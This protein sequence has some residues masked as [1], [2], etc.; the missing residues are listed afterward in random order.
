M[1]APNDTSPPRPEGGAA[2]PAARAVDGDLLA[3]HRALARPRARPRDRRAYYFGVTGRINAF[4]VAFQIPNLVRALVADA[5]LSS[6][7]VPVFSELLEKG[8]RKRAWRVASTPLLADAARP[9]RAHRALHPAR[10]AAHAAVR[11]SG[12]RRRARRRALAHPL[13]DRRPARA[14]RDRRRDPEQLRPLHRAGAH[15]GRLEPRRSSSASSSASRGSHDES[16]QLYVYAGSIVARDGDPAPAAAAVA[17]GAA[18]VGSRWSIDW[19]DPAVKRVLVLMLPGDD[20]R[21]AD[22]RQRRR[23][24]VLRV[25]A[26]RPGARAGGDRRGVPPLHAAAGDLLGRGRD[27][28]LPDARAARRPR[29]HR[30][31]PAS[32]RRRPAPDRLPARAG[33]RSCRSCS[34]SRSCA[35]STSAAS[36]RAEDTV[37]VARACGVLARARLQRLD[38]DAEPQL[39]RLQTTWIPTGVALGNLALNAALDAV[40]YRLGIWG[41]PLAT[42]IVNI[43][44][45]TRAARAA[46]SP[47]SASSTSGA[48]SGVVRA[49]RRRRRPRRGA[50]YGAWRG[51]DDVLGTGL[52]RPAVWRSAP[53]LAAGGRRLRRRSPGRWGCA[54]S[55]RCYR[56]EPGATSPPTRA[57]PPMEQ[58]RIRNF[59]I[60]AHI[61]HG[62]STLADR[63]LELTDTVTEPRH[64]RRSCSTR[65]TSSASAGSRSRPRP[66]A[67]RWKGHEL[68]LI[69]TPGHVDFTYEVSRSLQACEGALLVVD[70]AQGIEAQTLANA[71]LAIEND[72]EI[73]PVVNKIDLPQADPD[74]AAREIAELARRR[75]PSASC[76]SRR[77]PASG[78]DRGARR[79]RRADPARRRAI[80]TRRP[81]A[82]DLRLLL[83]PVPR[84][85]R[86]R[87]RRRRPL[88]DAA[89]RCARWRRAPSF[90]AEELGFMSPTLR[91]S[92]ALG[93][94]EVGYVITGLKDV[95]RLR[96][97]DTLT[98]RAAPGRRAAARLQG[99]QADGLRRALP[100]RLRRLPGAARRARAAEAERRA[101]SSTSPRRRRR[102]ASASAAASSACCT[103]RSSASGSSA[104]STSTCS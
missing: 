76:G 53:A 22:Q 97:G 82:L 84:R 95:S 11:R 90:D 18:T 33:Q 50:S 71:Y 94:G 5:A 104:S 64:A 20:R 47:A 26:A 78:V 42:S 75:R 74:G 24:H 67:C 27:G 38:A 17:A 23:R 1:D 51:L 103:W 60:I 99:R 40:F 73:V 57:E 87:P 9:R 79:D 45:A 100:D 77:R 80:P 65:W 10:A 4:T 13:P 28:A 85:R 49:H 7:F 46:A 86:V 88:L 14:L 32:A 62:K 101:R 35:S 36:S 72:L 44:A 89:S 12:R 39:L 96:V 54:S 58:D 68:N 59:S 63:I 91:P 29:R 43:V 41:I 30:R 93:A 48:R 81:R 15:A 19:R 52:R 70:A 61:D 92:T 21:R 83:R 2:T 69:D 66:C 34:P 6:A 16:A 31:L 8:E 3:R 56:C 55:R 102:S 98:S 25:A 37:I